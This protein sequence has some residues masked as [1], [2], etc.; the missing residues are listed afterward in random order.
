[1]KALSLI[2]AL[3]LAS[4]APAFAQQDG[5]KSSKY[6]LMAASLNPQQEQ[7]R[8]QMIR[9]QQARQQARD[10]KADKKLVRLRTHRTRHAYRLPEPA[11]SA[12]A[13]TTSQPQ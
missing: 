3:A 8:Q 9:K 4:T 1:M 10:A 5:H 7:A 2:L 6:P 12:A 13:T 11:G